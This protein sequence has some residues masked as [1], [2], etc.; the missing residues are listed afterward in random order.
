MNENQYHKNIFGFFQ[1]FIYLFIG[2]DIYYNYLSQSYDHIAVFNRIHDAFSRLPV[3]SD[4]RWSHLTVLGLTVF[5]SLATKSRK[6]INYDWNKHFTV[7]LV[8]GVLLFITSLAIFFFRPFSFVIDVSFYSITYLFGTVNIHV[9]LS[10]LSKRVGTKLKDDVW[11]ENEEAFK[12]NIDLVNDNDIFHVRL[13]YLYQKKVHDAVMNIDVFRGMAVM[14]L[15]GSG[16]TESIIIPYIKQVL[17]KGYSM[18]LYDYKFPDLAEIA[19]YHYLVNS[20]NDGPLSKHRFD[21]VN[22]DNIEKS[23]RCNP[24]SPRYIKTLAQAMDT[25]AALITAMAKTEG[26]SVGSGKFFAD[27]AINFLAAMIFFLAEH[28]RENGTRYCTL[29]HVIA[30]ASNSYEKIFSALLQQDQLKVIVEPYKSAFENQALEQLEGQI[31]T[32]RVNLA[33][34]ASYESFWVFSGDEV[35]FKVSNP[36]C[37]SILVL[38]N[39]PTTIESN[40]AFFASIIS[41]CRVEVNQKHNI[42]CSF[43]FDEAPT[44]YL[45]KINE[46]ISTARSNLVSVVLGFQ[47]LNQLIKDYGDKVAKVI[48][49][50]MGSII[51]GAVRSRE[52]LD[53]LQ[54]MF[55]KVKQVTQGMSVDRDRTSVSMNE[56]LDSVIPSN[57][58]TNLNAG[59]VV[60]V[61]STSKHT[62]FGDF[63]P[64][65]FKGKVQL[66]LE[67]IK[68]EKSKYIELPTYYKFK[69]EKQ[70]QTVLKKNWNRIFNEISDLL[71]E[72]YIEQTD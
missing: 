29:P 63:K 37:P 38:S 64:N 47:D 21:V 34:I 69:S 39:N 65:M 61:V 26:Q 15:P 46:L 49:N 7:P 68:R 48:Q 55:G 22:I 16:K 18:L 32:V 4:V 6:N 42:P 59:E 58:I 27:S 54:P 19:Y 60:A 35:D 20:Q 30:M 2:L 8:L 9:A 5:V 72:Y 50:V 14:G 53:W 56:R 24:I 23:R 44:V 12:Q 25:S 28:D 51:S 52:S 57:K 41:R 70:K 36:D 66:D 71:D 67:A 13:K 62:E 11:N 45:Y 40:S 43:I 33:K 10:N 1:I 17:S 31:A 3:I